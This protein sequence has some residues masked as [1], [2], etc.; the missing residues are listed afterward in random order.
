MIW[1]DTTSY[2]RYDQERK[3]TTLTCKLTEKISFIVHK[4]IYF[5]DEWLLTCRYLNVEQRQLGTTEME[6]AKALATLKMRNLLT[7]EKAEVSKA[8]SELSFP[9]AEELA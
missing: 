3:P 4:H 8:I 2:S 7:I 6:Q 1:T 5:G 9:S